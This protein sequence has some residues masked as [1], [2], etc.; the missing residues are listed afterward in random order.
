MPFKLPDLQTT[1]PNQKYSKNF[2][3]NN[4]HDRSLNRQSSQRFAGARNVAGTNNYS[5]S[6]RVTQMSE[7]LPTLSMENSMNAAVNTS[8]QNL[9]EIELINDRMA[10]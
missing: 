1:T 8:M 2:K 9:D 7:I 6:T 4:T 5:F 10:H 3:T